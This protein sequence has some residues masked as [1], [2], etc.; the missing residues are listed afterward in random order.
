MN[1]RPVLLY[2]SAA[3]IIL[4]TSQC[5]SFKGI[6]IDPN[7]NTFYVARFEQ[8][9]LDADIPPP[10]TLPLTFTEALIDIIRKETRLNYSDVDPDVE[11]SGTITGYEISSQ[12]PQEDQ[13]TA[14]SQLTIKVNVEYN[15]HEKDKDGE[16]K[17]KQG[18]YHQALDNEASHAYILFR[19]G[20]YDSASWPANAG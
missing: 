18:K 9:L 7:V 4:L 19:L 13:T 1:L 14:F 16:D 11:F 6:S 10:P 17:E 15:K 5:Y 12:T 3:I 2:L 8:A 20:R